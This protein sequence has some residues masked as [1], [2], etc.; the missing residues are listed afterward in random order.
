MQS[1]LRSSKPRSGNMAGLFSS[2]VIISA[3]I[4]E[5]IYPPRLLI[6]PTRL[7]LK[8]AC[9]LCK[10]FQNV[11]ELAVWQCFRTTILRSL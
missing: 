2:L 5:F 11:K 6:Q 1:Y 8:F 3:N 10:E 7:I 9:L 4:F